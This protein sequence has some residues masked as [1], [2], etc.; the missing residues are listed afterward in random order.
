MP[1]QPVP[2]RRRRPGR[3]ARA[4]AGSGSAGRRRPPATGPGSRRPRPSPRPA[5]AARRRRGS[6]APRA[7][8]RARP[9]P[10]TARC[11]ARPGP[12]PSRNR[13][14][15]TAPAARYRMP[16]NGT[17]AGATPSRV[18]AARAG[19]IR[20]SP[21]ALSTGSGR[22][23]STTTDIPARAASTAVPSPTGPPPTTSRSAS[24]WLTPVRSP[25]RRAAFS[26]RS[27]T[28][29]MTAFST[30][31]QRR[32]HPAG[33]HQRQREPLDHDGDVV[34][35]PEPAVRAAG[36]Q[37]EPGDDDDAGVPARP[38]R[39]DAPPAQGLGAEREHEHRPAQP[40][41]ERAVGDQHLDD[42][43][44]QQPG[45][46]GHHRRE[47]A[48]PG[49][50]P[51]PGERPGGV[52]G[53]DRQLGQ[54]L[55]RRPAGSARCRARSRSRLRP[56]FAAP[57]ARR[58]SP[59]QQHEFGAEARA[60]R[61]QQPVRVPAWAGRRPGSAPARAAPRPRTGCR[62]PPATPG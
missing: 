12:A 9:A 33:V 27:R 4:R 29:R 23:S 53:R 26:T 24:R 49:L 31:E 39:G 18:S 13:A 54:P 11:A 36:D 16:R 45:V 44:D 19:G 22:R 56:R 6:G 37:R 41:Q 38:E 43:A 17:P 7:R 10:T 34:G 50:H 3:P 42:A 30:R 40:G 46:Q 48:A 5:R 35:M 57:L 59:T 15:D 14:L 8:P 55:E 60:H 20:P 2:R 25:R 1:P 47:V 62:P 52:A 51:A 21:H 32:G 58:R 28:R 61:H